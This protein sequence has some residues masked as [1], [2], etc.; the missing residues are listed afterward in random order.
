[1]KVDFINLH[2]LQFIISILWH[3]TVLKNCCEVGSLIVAYN[4]VI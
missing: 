2:S 1:M 4:D 3:T